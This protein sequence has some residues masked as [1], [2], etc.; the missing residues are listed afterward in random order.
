M[1]I[2]KSRHADIRVSERCDLKDVSSKDLVK[3]AYT[4]GLTIKHF[5]GSVEKYMLEKLNGVR[6]NGRQ[7]VVLYRG[8]VF[9]FNHNER[10]LIT[11]YP[12]PPEIKEDYD[13]Q[14]KTIK[15]K[16]YGKKSR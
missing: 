1:S 3:F 13:K 11:M 16:R 2:T 7:R 12:L 5:K 4:K 10:M 8:Y 14:I 6:D 9:V 15:E